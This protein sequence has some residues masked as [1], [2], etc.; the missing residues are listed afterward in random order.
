MPASP[1]PLWLGSNGPRMLTLTG[2]ASDGWVS[3]LS[4]YVGPAAVPFPGLTGDVELWVA[5][6]TDWSVNLGLDTFICWPMSAPLDQLDVFAREVVPAVR[7]GVAE[8]RAAR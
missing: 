1:V 3:P 7:Q 6:L 4:T 8:R 2:R 5:T